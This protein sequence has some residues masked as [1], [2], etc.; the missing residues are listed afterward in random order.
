MRSVVHVVISDIGEG[1]SDTIASLRGPL[2][3][4]FLLTWPGGSSTIVRPFPFS[5]EV[6]VEGG[7]RR[8]LVSRTDRYELRVFDQAGAPQML[9]RRSDATPV[10]ID[11]SIVASYLSNPAAVPPPLSD[12]PDAVETY[13]SLVSSRRGS[14]LPTHADVLFDAENNI[15][16]REPDR[17]WS[18]RSADAYAVYAPDG[19]AA[20]TVDIPTGLAVYHIG[21]DYIV[22][23]VVDE[24]NVQYVVVHELVKR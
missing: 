1:S 24:L 15:W 21:S 19:T 16:V 7:G 6:N 23:R 3:K 22:G 12:Y 2:Q 10:P 4:A 9:I 17:S 11:E 13:R 8:I 14:T 20:A 18:P 5:H